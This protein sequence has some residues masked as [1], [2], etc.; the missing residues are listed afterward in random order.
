MGSN[1]LFDK[2]I[3]PNARDKQAQLRGNGTLEN[4]TAQN[5][6]CLHVLEGRFGVVAHRAIA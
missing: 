2:R 6:L 1:T 4:R 5:L 3:A